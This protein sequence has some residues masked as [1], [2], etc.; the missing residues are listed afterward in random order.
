MRDEIHRGVRKEKR[1]LKCNNTQVTEGYNP[2]GGCEMYNIR[3][4]DKDYDVFQRRTD[5]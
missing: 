3:I 5:E 1:S 2:I 4:N